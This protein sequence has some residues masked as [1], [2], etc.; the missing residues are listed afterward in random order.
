MITATN[1]MAR[2]LR[3][4]PSFELFLDHHDNVVVVEG[5][6]KT[7]VRG[8][9]LV[10]QPGRIN[11]DY[12][13]AHEIAH[14]IDATD[15]ELFAPRLA[16]RDTSS[17]SASAIPTAA[18]T[19]RETRV[20]GIH[21]HILKHASIANVNPRF[22]TLE[23]FA[24]RMAEIMGNYIIPVGVIGHGVEPYHARYVERVVEAHG[25]TSM[26]AILDE[27]NRKLALIAARER[28]A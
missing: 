19:W 21:Y 14:V 24:L 26:P 20:F 8:G 22:A 27:W 15:E 17:Q 12:M 2:V 13:F 11:S 16:L 6:T 3:V 9:V 28:L 1:E 5:P 25:G 23:S 10:I 18:E 7:E 4:A